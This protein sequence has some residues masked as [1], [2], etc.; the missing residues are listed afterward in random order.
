MFFN[1]NEVFGFNMSFRQSLISILKKYLF[2]SIQSQ[3]L[4]DTLSEKKLD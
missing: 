2:N 1:I 3:N 4:V